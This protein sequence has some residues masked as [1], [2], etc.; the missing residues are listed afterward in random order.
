MFP[1]R[2]PIP[3]LCPD[4]C[5]LTVWPQEGDQRLNGD[6]PVCQPAAD[7][8]QLDTEASPRQCW[9]RSLSPRRGASMPGLAGFIFKLSYFIYLLCV[10]VRTPWSLAGNV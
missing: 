5:P 4:N 6:S 9:P 3:R 7:E 1:G 2:A 10:C 8:G